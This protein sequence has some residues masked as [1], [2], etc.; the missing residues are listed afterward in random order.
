MIPKCILVFCPVRP[1]KDMCS[2]PIDK[3]KKL[4][5]Y[6]FMTQ[7]H[8]TKESCANVRGGA[9]EVTQQK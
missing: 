1:L 2:N 8:F 3:V 5:Q 6:A 9:E 7:D 4:A